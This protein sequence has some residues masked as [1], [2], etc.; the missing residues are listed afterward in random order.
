MRST[1]RIAVAAALLVALNFALPTIGNALPP[2]PIPSI[3]PSPTPGPSVQPPRPSPTDPQGDGPNAGTDGTANPDG[4]TPPF[5]L[6]GPKNTA[7]LVETLSELTKLGIPLKRALISGMGRLPVA[8]IA[9]W[10]DDWHAPR[11]CPEP[12]E[13]QGVDVFAPK[14]APA[15]AVAE[16]TITRMVN[17]PVSGKAVYLTDAHG[18]YYFYGHL[19]RFAKDLREGQEVHVGQVVGFVGNTGNAV[20]TPAHIH[21][22]IHPGGGVAV[23]PKPHLDRWLAQAEREARAMIARRADE[24]AM[25]ERVDFRLR[26][27]FDLE[28]SG[29]IGSSAQQFLF[30]AGMQPAVSSLEMAQQTLGQM[31]WEIDWADLADAELAELARQVGALQTDAGALTISPWGPYGPALMSTEQVYGAPTG[32]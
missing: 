19:N 17:G 7:R 5:R 30:F 25:A 4:T 1:R 16:G 13:H 27:A 15:L 8:G 14:N 22:E 12:H 11:C 32:D 3:F 21:F 6:S 10:S 29:A 23:P 26:R 28:G 24:L 9:Y 18:T 31:A 2:V 20:G